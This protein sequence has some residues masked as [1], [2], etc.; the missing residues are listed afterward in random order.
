ML[1][2]CCTNRGGHGS[3]SAL[4]GCEDGGSSS[5]GL[6]W[7]ALVD[8]GPAGLDGLG[9]E[10]RTAGTT[11]ARGSTAGDSSDGLTIGDVGGS[12]AG[13]GSESFEYLDL[14][15]ARVCMVAMGIRSRRLRDGRVV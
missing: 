11:F 4:D 2:S 13:R 5:C 1:N 14:R 8:D 12:D 7:R 3:D 10:G 15:G 6:G 9:A